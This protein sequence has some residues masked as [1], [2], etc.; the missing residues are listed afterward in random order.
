MTST[1]LKKL[2]IE[3]ENQ[4]IVS[5][6]IHD[7]EVKSVITRLS[8]TNNSVEIL[9]CTEKNEEYELI[10]LDPIFLSCRDFSYQNVI[11]EIEIIEKD[12]LLK[13]LNKFRNY[14]GIDSENDLSE[15]VSEIKS[16][17]LKLAKL[18]PSVGISI[19]LIFSQIEAFQVNK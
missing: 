11:F 16:K 4:I 2:N 7:S 19:L 15:L 10:F 8:E 1:R 9:L 13:N 18:S 14:L 5:P 6:Q 3:I 12:D 17:E